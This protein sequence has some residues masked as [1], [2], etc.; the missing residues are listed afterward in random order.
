MGSEGCGGTGVAKSPEAAAGAACGV[1]L[2]TCFGTGA[3]PPFTTGV[4]FA[5]ARLGT[6]DKAGGAAL[7]F[8]P[9]VTYFSDFARTIV[10]SRSRT[11]LYLLKPLSININWPLELSSRKGRR[12]NHPYDSSGSFDRSLRLLTASSHFI[13]VLLH[14]LSCVKYRRQRKTLRN[15]RAITRNSRH[16]EPLTPIPKFDG[17]LAQHSVKQLFP[18]SLGRESYDNKLRRSPAC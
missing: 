1:P 2:A 7:G 12:H 14:S 4:A 3:E 18:Q 10:T 5:A 11:G 15:I 13:E 17:E 16:S 9:R 8:A 6:D